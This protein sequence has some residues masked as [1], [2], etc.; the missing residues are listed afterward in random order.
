MVELIRA[1]GVFCEPPAD[2]HTRLAE[3]LGFSKSPCA[4]AYQ[5]IFCNDLPPFASVYL[6]N[7]GVMGGEALERISGFWQALQREVPHEPDHLSR[8]LGL[9]A[10]LE[11]KQI[12][13]GEPA[14]A[15]LIQRSRA[16]LFWEHL[17][18]W[19]PTYLDRVESIAKD[20]VYGD[21]ARLLS[22]TLLS[23]FECLGPLENPPRHLAA[24]SGLPDP[25]R[26]GAAQFFSSLFA[27]VQLGFILLAED[28]NNLAD[29]IGILPKDHDRQAILKDLLREAPKETLGGLADMAYERSCYISEKWSSLGEL[30][31]HWERRAK[32]SGEML[33]QLSQ[34]LEKEA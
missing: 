13:A 8:L 7:E 33:Q 16:A 29:E 24:S 34:D 2:E 31:S 23:D 22:E 6:S 32:E 20:T 15:L 25:R 18:P 4:D 11:E 5:E 3:I 10:F 1:L 12:S 27:P 9:A 19:M 26:K 30:C 14:R 17:L 21:W 28:L